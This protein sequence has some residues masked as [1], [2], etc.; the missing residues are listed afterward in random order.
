MPPDA[1]GNK[2]LGEACDC[3]SSDIADRGKVSRNGSGKCIKHREMGTHS[4]GEYTWP[5]ETDDRNLSARKASR[6]RNFSGNHK[7]NGNERRVSGKSVR[8]ERRCHHEGLQASASTS[9]KDRKVSSNSARWKGDIEAEGGRGS[10]RF[11]YGGAGL[12]RHPVVNG[13][14]EV[15]LDEN[16]SEKLKKEREI[17]N[18][19]RAWGDVPADGKKSRGLD[20]ERVKE[21]RSFVRETSFRL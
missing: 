19:V 2:C 6:E 18:M 5:A 12:S 13:F 8:D 4:G 15:E 10:P 11:D 7:K 21:R 16:I 14:V 3:N 9:I 20:T 1:R 17:V